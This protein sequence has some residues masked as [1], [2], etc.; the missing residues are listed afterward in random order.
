MRS[1][2]KQKQTVWRSRVST[3][4]SGI[5]TIT[6]YDKPE[7]T[8]ATVGCSAGY[9]TS[10][11]AGF[12]LSY[13]RYII[14]HRSTPSGEEFYQKAEEGDVLWIDKEPELDSDGNI[15]LGDDGITPITPPD[16]VIK[17][18]LTSLRVGTARYGIQNAGNVE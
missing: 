4:L 7:S 2:K 17:R 11:T 12:I 1:L 15:L 3:E 5:D 6:L 18:K 9:P 10:T 13:D 8:S 14:V 16:F